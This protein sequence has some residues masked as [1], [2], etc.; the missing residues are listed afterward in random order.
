M[1]G[2]RQYA[3]WQQM[4]PRNEALDCWKYALAALRLSGIDL[5]ERAKKK[6]TKEEEKPVNTG[7]RRLGRVGSFSRI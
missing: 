2:T 5:K 3:E 4:R 7:F 1:R 6:E